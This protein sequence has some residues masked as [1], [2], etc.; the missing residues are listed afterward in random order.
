MADTSSPVKRPLREDG[1]E[2]E[3]GDGEAEHQQ[4]ANRGSGPRHQGAGQT[5]EQVGGDHHGVAPS[6]SA[7]H[8]VSP[9]S[10]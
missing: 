8:A 9:G 1:A 7:C 5:N 10:R 6:C 3:C 4:Q 2:H